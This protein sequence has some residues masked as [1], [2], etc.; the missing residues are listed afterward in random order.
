MVNWET[1]KR[2]VLEYS[3]LAPRLVTTTLTPLPAVKLQTLPADC[4][5]VQYLAYG[6]Q[7][8]FQEVFLDEVGTLGWANENGLL[9]ITPILELAEDQEELDPLAII[10]WA[11][12]T[13]DDNTET[14]TPTIP[15]AHQHLV[16]D[17]EQAIILEVE[18]DEVA[19][20]PA[21]YAIGQTQVDRSKALV[22]LRMRSMTLRTRVS[23][24]LDTP[25]GLW[26]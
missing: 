3:K 13:T 16:D 15:V 10:Y 24:S 23:Q 19:R 14:V 20:G 7:G 8:G 22:D 21:T 17:L 9:I 18:A 4:L 11:R 25:L 1:Y 5:W 2:A 6:E 12:Y 26:A